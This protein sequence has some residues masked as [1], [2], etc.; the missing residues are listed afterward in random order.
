ML[1]NCGL[2]FYSLR[3]SG[4]AGVMVAI[5]MGGIRIIGKFEGVHWEED[6]WDE[7]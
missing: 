4:F 3:G 5:S 6:A 7:N 1:G 2:F